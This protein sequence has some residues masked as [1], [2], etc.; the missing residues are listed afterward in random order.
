MEHLWRMNICFLATFMDCTHCCACHS[1][2]FFDNLYRLPQTPDWSSTLSLMSPLSLPTITHQC[3]V[4]TGTLLVSAVCLASHV[5]S[6]MWLYR[7]HG[8][9]IVHLTYCALWCNYIHTLRTY[10]WMHSCIQYS[11]P[12]LLNDTFISQLILYL[13][14]VC[15]TLSCNHHLPLLVC[16]CVCLCVFLYQEL[17]MSGLDWRCSCTTAGESPSACST[18]TWCRGLWGSTCT[19]WG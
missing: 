10:T 16:V 13:L 15:C 2:L 12:Y 5:T 14:P 11:L 9:F 6:G 18:W 19:L 3:W 8:R 7:A 17:D 4:P 1:H